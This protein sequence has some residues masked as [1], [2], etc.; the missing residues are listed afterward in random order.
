MSQ[1]EFVCVSF[2][3]GKGLWNVTYLHLLT[4]N[5]LLTQDGSRHGSTSS[6]SQQM[7]L[8]LCMWKY[9]Q[10]EEKPMTNRVF[11]FISLAKCI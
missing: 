3:G 4:P 2:E 7:S 11:M 10:R 9:L 1:L 5:M 6:L 8:L